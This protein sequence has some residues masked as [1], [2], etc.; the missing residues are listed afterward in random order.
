MC[1]TLMLEQAFVQSEL[2]EDVFCAYQED[3]VACPV[4]QCD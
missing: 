1:V 4:R 2:D 3:V